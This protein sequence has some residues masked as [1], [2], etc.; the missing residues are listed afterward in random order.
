L[1][2]LS[3]RTTSEGLR[4][5]FEKFGRVIYGTSLPLLEQNFFSSMQVQGQGILNSVLLY[6]PARVATDRNSGYSRGFGFV[7]YET[8]EEAARGIESM[9][10]K[11]C[12]VNYLISFSYLFI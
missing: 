6:I 1:A 12:S 7:R 11:V 8:I 5:A 2:G 3:K 10:G 4:E 9:D